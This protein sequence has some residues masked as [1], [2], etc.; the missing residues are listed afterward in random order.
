MVTLKKVTGYT[1]KDRVSNQEIRRPRIKK[2]NLLKKE[3]RDR[4]ELKC[5]YNARGYI[6]ENCKGKQSKEKRNR[7][8]TS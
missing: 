4:E 7:K 3:W 2:N 1:L 6:T 8:I 5:G